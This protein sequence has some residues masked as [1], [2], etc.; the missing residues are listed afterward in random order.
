MKLYFTSNAPS[1]DIC[2]THEYDV[3]KVTFDTDTNMLKFMTLDCI[4]LQI[5]LTGLSNIQIVEDAYDY[6]PEQYEE[7][8]E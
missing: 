8:E 1:P 6:E 7:I 2:K 3:T 5:E 4:E